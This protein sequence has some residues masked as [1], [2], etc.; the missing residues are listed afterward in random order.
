MANKN[1][2]HVSHIKSQLPRKIEEGEFYGLTPTTDNSEAE[3][4]SPIK[5]NLAKRPTAENLIE[6]E[7]AVNYLK[8][9]ETLT[10]KNTEDEI[11]AFVNENDFNEAQEIVALG[12]AQEKDERVSDIARL[13]SKIS[14]EI[15]DKLG[16]LESKFNTDIENINETITDMEL[17]IS[18]SL[19]DL[20]SRIIDNEEV[21]QE[22][23]ETV[24]ELADQIEGEVGEQLGQVNQRIDDI[25]LAV[26]ASLNDLNSRIIETDG[27]F[28]EIENTFNEF[29]EGIEHIEHTISASLN[30]L[31]T[32]IIETN[33]D[34]DN[35]YSDLTE[36]VTTLENEAYYNGSS[37]YIDLG[38][39]SGLLW[40]SYNLPNAVN[41]T[42]QY[43]NLY[44]A[45]AET[46]GYEECELGVNRSFDD[47][48]YKWKWTQSGNSTPIKY[49]SS[50]NK[51]QVEYHNDAAAS[52]WGGSWRLPTKEEV[53][54]LI[55]NTTCTWVGNNGGI[56]TF[57]S[58]INGKKL[59]VPCA[60]AAANTTISDKQESAYFWTRDI[61]ETDNT[62]AYALIC[63]TQTP[64]ITSIGREV[65]LPIRPVTQPK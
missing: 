15:G 16:E 22:L 48:S 34:I 11:V 3:G 33:E 65:G 44:F 43:T 63:N 61:D 60:G 35:K 18:A 41:P 45:W 50:D 7:I 1:F 62:K 54:E 47:T 13:E 14:E 64:S 8:G 42:D 10:I 2:D 27:K 39:P 23:G 40:G 38:L 24:G 58:N 49:N 59:Y 55:D 5:L 25:E 6:G 37:K 19:N 51:T 32:R 20:N 53:Q 12:L 29:D 46:E 31:N 36:Q 52:C 28:A 30:D 17:V 57:T 56:V 26:S 21:I 9:H 4:S